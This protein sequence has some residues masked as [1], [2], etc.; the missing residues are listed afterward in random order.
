MKALSAI[1][2]MGLASR[3]FLP[4]P[5]QKNA[6]PRANFSQVKVR[7]RLLRN[8]PVSDDGTSQLMGKQR[9]KAREIDW[10]LQRTSFPAV[11]V[12]GIAHR[13]ECIEGNSN[14]QCD[15]QEL[16]RGFPEPQCL[17]QRVQVSDPKIEILKTPK[18][19]RLVDIET[20]SVI[21]CALLRGL[22]AGRKGRSS[23]S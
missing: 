9:D 6:A 4:I 10:M 17:T 2:A 22:P 7:C 11:H 12:Y 21:F 20:A 16:Y 1:C 15:M 23:P 5:R 3:I 8:A 18:I 13:L 19:A 14:R